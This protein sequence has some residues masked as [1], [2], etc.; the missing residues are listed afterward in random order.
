LYNKRSNASNLIV[1]AEIN[2]TDGL[3]V[4]PDNWENNSSIQFVVGTATGQKFSTEEWEL[5]EFMG[6]VFIPSG[7]YWHA[8]TD[9]FCYVAIGSGGISFRL[10]PAPGSSPSCRVRLVKDL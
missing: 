5:L 7:S 8:I 6:A 2:G 1:G 3:V 10:K 9:G 4:L